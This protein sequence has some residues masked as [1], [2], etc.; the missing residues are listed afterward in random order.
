MTGGTPRVT[1]I[2]AGVSFVDALARGL[3]A[4]A[5][6]PLELARG[7]VLLPTRRACRALQEAFLRASDG[8][9][10]LLPRLLPL[11]DVD[12]EELLLAGEEA[13]SGLVD[14]GGLADGGGS[15]VDLPPAMAPLRRQLLLGRL[16]QRLGKAR[17]ERLR[18][19]Q[20]V[21]LA[22]ELDYPVAL[23]IL[24]PDISHKSD[25]GGVVLD[26]ETPEAVQ[27]AARAM[28]ARV[29]QLLPEA[30]VTGFTVQRMARRP[31]AHELIIGAAID[32]IFG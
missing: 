25:V 6:D 11:G 12:A 9:A 22:D 10:L 4:R 14:G 3:L 32:P 24:S 29:C 17:G 18:E 7:T 19:D 28:R 8:R 16:I 5:G 27:T 13:P 26:L 31:S 1:T 23:K 2:A 30:R 15:A 20:A 21:R